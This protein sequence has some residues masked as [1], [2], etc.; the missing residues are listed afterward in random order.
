MLG[1]SRSR[2]SG[3]LRG[4]DVSSDFRSCCQSLCL[5][6]MSTLTS[7][8]ELSPCEGGGG[9]ASIHMLHTGDMSKLGYILQE[10]HLDPTLAELDAFN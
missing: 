7:G 9:A 3:A 10:F 2:E 1:I 5:G 8:I 6:L 4:A